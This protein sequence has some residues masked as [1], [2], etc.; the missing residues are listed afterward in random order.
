ML[1]QIFLVKKDRQNNQFQ[2]PQLYKMQSSRNN[3]IK[4]LGLG[5]VFYLSAKTGY[6]QSYLYK[7]GMEDSIYSEI[8]D[9]QRKLWIQLPQFY[10]P[11]KGKTYPVVYILDGETQLRAV[12]A[13]CNYYEGHFLPDMILVGVSNADNRMRDLTPSEIKVRYGGPVAEETGGAEKFTEFMEFELIPYIDSILPVTE[14]RTLIGHSFGGLFT[15]NTLLNHTHLFRNY[16]AIDPSL[17]WDDQKFLDQSK[18]ALQNKDFNEQYLFLSLSAASI[19]MQDEHITLENV[20][21]DTSDYTLFTRSIMEFADFVEH[22]AHDGL[23]FSWEKYPNDLHGTVSLP[24]VRDGLMSIFEWYQ[25]ESFWKFN[26]FSTPTN[27]LVEL[28]KARERKLKENFGYFVPPFE[29]ELF[30]MIAY[31]SLQ[32]G[33]PEKSKAFFE[34]A[35]AYYPES[36]NAL[37]SMADY[38]IS[39][40]DNENAILYLRKAFVLSGNKYYSDRIKEIEK[41]DY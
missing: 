38:Y 7:T 27:E 4:V 32:S 35:I 24:S 34:M 15:I 39:Q 1:F 16:I 10:E 37:D 29:E 9:E 19:H 18:L 5:I 22:Q 30:N 20:M 41:S 2:I 40:N 31:M 17:D 12:D 36:P 33:Q 6:A 3:V 8:L 21:T 14:Y 28:V 13:V 26:D 23:K 25:L 11:D